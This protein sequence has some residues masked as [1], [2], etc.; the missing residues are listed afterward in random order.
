MPN[1]NNSVNTNAFNF[2]CLSLLFVILF[3]M[4]RELFLLQFFA[5]ASILR[6][7]QSYLYERLFPVPLTQFYPEN[8]WIMPIDRKVYLPRGVADQQSHSITESYESIP[9]EQRIVDM[10]NFIALPRRSQI[11]SRA[12]S[13]YEKYLM[14]TMFI[15]VRVFRLLLRISAGKKL[16][17]D[18]QRIH[19][20][21]DI[22]SH[23]KK[24]FPEVD[25]SYITPDYILEWYN[26]IGQ[27]GF[28]VFV[29]SGLTK[30]TKVPEDTLLQIYPTPWKQFILTPRLNR[31]MKTGYEFYE[32]IED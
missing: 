22:I 5:D 27:S 13:W 3:R 26:M 29:R 12:T 31:L 17:A 28:N 32:N 18:E 1:K 24:K 25:F 10:S 14:S 8:V 4:L 30:P 2:C 16:L 20:A 7:D 6:I 21:S 23:L 9:V 15:D 11:Y 19:T